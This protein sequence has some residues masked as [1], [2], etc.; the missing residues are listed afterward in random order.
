VLVVVVDI[1][2]RRIMAPRIFKIC[3]KMNTERIFLNVA[4]K[5]RILLMGFS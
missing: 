5:V 4:I 1:N 3:F 2:K